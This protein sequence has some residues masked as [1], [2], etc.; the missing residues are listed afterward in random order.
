M[1]AFQ[2]DE[3]VEDRFQEFY[4]SDLSENEVNDDRQSKFEIES[5]FTQRAV[6]KMVHLWKKN[7][8]RELHQFL[9][10]G[11]QD[12]YALYFV[13]H[14]TKKREI[15]IMNEMKHGQQDFPECRL[16]NEYGSYMHDLVYDYMK[17]WWNHF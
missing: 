6:A 3:F 8:H 7:A 14:N 2:L 4:M 12:L 16:E 1:E 13:D 9:E 5:E 15:R 17:N 11:L 10:S